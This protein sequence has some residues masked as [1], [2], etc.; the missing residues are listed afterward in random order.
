MAAR[1][2]AMESGTERDGAIKPA[3]RRLSVIEPAAELGNAA[4]TCRRRGLDSRSD[5]RAAPHT[6]VPPLYRGPALPAPTS[7]RADS[8]L[9]KLGSIR[10]CRLSHL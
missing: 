6:H 1:S 2:S 3:R 9:H 5:R 7:R 10:L 8:Y 4:E